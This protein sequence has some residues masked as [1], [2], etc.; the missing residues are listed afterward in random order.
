M[1]VSTVE[2]GTITF[3]LHAIVAGGQHQPR[4]SLVS[5][6]SFR[7]DRRAGRRPCSCVRT[8]RAP[9]GTDGGHVTLVEEHGHPRAL[10]MLKV[11][12]EKSG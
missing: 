5:A 3:L 9:W 7:A 1:T 8:A 10:R 4:R 11:A 2:E 6:P 12:A